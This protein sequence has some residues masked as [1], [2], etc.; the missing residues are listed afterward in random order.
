MNTTCRIM[1][2]SLL[3]ASFAFAA[4]E[5]SLDDLLNIPT[6]PKTD[7]PA[8]DDGDAKPKPQM[9]E[10]DVKTAEVGGDDFQKA[11]FDM[12]EAASRLTET[13]DPGLDT[14]RAQQRAIAR[15]DQLI[16]ELAKQQ[17]QSQ[18]KSKAKKQDTGQ[19][20]NQSAQQQQGEANANAQQAMQDSQATSGT[21][22]TGNL[23]EEP[24]AEKLAEWGNLPPRLRDQLLQ[25]LEDNFSQLYRQMTE[26]YYQRLGE[27]GE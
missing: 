12:K 4:D 14:Q 20:Q 26:R 16:S 3:A 25:G 15:L 11:I 13:S 7:K 5:P 19:Q 1:M 22:Q 27:Q 18:S 17:S 24:L 6:T 10:P 9:P 23:A 21:P 2:I 8:P